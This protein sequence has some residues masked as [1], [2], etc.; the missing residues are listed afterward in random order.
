VTFVRLPD[1]TF[2]YILETKFS[3][4]ITFEIIK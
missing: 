1:L 4:A 2:I 3:L